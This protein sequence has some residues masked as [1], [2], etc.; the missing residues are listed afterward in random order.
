MT[1]SNFFLYCNHFI[2]ETGS[3]TKPQAH[4]LA[5]L[6]GQKAPGTFPSLLLRTR[7]RDIHKHRCIFMWV[8]GVRTE[9]IR[10]A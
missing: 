5:S 3:L 9:D 2:F 4:R 10:L 8:I 7:V 6:A 1:I